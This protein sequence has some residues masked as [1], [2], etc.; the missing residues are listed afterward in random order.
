[1]PILKSVY[2]E[3]NSLTIQQRLVFFALPA[4][5]RSQLDQRTST[6]RRMFLIIKKNIYIN[7]AKLRNICNNFINLQQ[8]WEVIR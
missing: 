4:A 1:M 5:C 7:Q 8:A 3:L 6:V 2:Q